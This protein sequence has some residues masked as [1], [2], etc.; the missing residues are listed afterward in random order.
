MIDNSDVSLHS[1]K[2]D[3]KTLMTLG[4]I[5]ASDILLQLIGTKLPGIDFVGLAKS[6]GCEAVRVERPQ[7][8]TPRL[9]AALESPVPYL[10]DVAVV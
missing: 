2:Y 5:P 3:L 7:D 9:T 6:M 8:L 1:G 10:V 4:K